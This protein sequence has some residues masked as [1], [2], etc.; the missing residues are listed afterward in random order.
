MA[1][2]A[3]GVTNELVVS[4]QHRLLVA[5]K[6]AERM[7]GNREVL[8]AAKQLL[9][10]DGVDI[11][12]DFVDVTYYH[13][14]FDQNEIIF[15][16]GIPSESLY[17]GAEARKSLSAA[18]RQEIATLFPKLLLLNFVPKSCRSII[19]GKRARQLA[20]RLCHNNKPLV[21]E[22]GAYV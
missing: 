2:N 17:L 10:I 1:V 12:N 16:R 19:R 5:S 6:V 8:V 13:I 11:A 22:P 7:F 18:G 15:A 20:D 3:A 21:D 14:L 9:A 4:P